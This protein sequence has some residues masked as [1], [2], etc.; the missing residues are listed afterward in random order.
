MQIPSKVTLSACFNVK[1][2]LAGCVF[3]VHMGG[4]G[5]GALSIYMGGTVML[6]VLEYRGYD[7]VIH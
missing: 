6:V 5:G 1:Y 2:S 3:G 4:R 7:G